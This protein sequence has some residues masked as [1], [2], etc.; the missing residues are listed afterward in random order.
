LALPP[1]YVLGVCSQQ[2]GRGCGKLRNEKPFML[3][4]LRMLDRA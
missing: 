2:T 3:S 4:A 1:Y